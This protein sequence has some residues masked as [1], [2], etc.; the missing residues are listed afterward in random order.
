MAGTFSAKKGDVELI[1]RQLVKD[2]IVMESPTEPLHYRYNFDSKNV[3]L[4]VGV[5]KYLCYVFHGWEPVPLYDLPYS[6]SFPSI[7]S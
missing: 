4:Q 2:D 6:P 1:F 7:H 5:E 3:D